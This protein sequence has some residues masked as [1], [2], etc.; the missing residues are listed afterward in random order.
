MEEGGEGGGGGGEQV[1]GLMGY[2]I[3]TRLRMKAL[4]FRNAVCERALKP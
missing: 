2:T 1:V 4:W 3:N